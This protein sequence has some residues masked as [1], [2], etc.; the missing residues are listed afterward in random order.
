MFGDMM[1]EVYDEQGNLVNTAPGGKRRGLNRVPFP[2]RMKPPKVPAA[3]S[4]VQ[5]PG[6]FT[7]PR[8]PEGTYSVRLIKGNDTYES[9][10]TLVPDPRSTATP[11]D[12][13]VQY[14][15]ALLLYGMVGRLGYVV[16][17]LVS[18]RDQ[19]RERAEAL[20]R[21]R[22]TDRLNQYADRLEAFR[23]EI[24]STST[25]GFWSGEEF[26]REKLVDLYGAVNGYEGRPTDSQLERIAV[27]ETQLVQAE[28]GFG[29]FIGRDLENLNR[30]LERSQQEPLTLLTKE[31][32]ES[33]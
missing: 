9:S 14:Q 5:S 27:L 15:T 29:E 21:G 19:A 10:V 1:V 28:E 20:G 8:L 17:A 22:T 30:Q 23:G 31:A 32:W 6:A 24:V 16:D 7:G 33:Q 3:G 25:A 26:L 11:E 4:L 2:T 18:L 13:Q 12:R